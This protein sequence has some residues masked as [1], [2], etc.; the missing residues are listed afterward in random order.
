MS[1]G[2]SVGSEEDVRTKKINSCGRKEESKG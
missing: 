1:G 2:L